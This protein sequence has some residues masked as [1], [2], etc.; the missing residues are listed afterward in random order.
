MNLWSRGIEAGRAS[1][2]KS[3]LLPILWDEECG[4]EATPDFGF[5][6]SQDGLFSACYGNGFG[7][8]FLTGRESFG[9][10]LLN[11]LLY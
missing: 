8:N 1:S 7:G 10:L 9:A 2:Q 6:N 11:G 5:G 3:A 4:W